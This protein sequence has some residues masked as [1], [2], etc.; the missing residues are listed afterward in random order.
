MSV[1]NVWA[2]EGR[3]TPATMLEEEGTGQRL[4]ASRVPG[5][6]THPVAHGTPDPYAHP[7]YQSALTPSGAGSTCA[8]DLQ[9]AWALGALSVAGG[10]GILC[11]PLGAAGGAVAGAFGIV[12]ANKA[13]LGGLSAARGARTVSIVGVVLCGLQILSIPFWFRGL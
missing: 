6:H 7:S 2:A 12:L 9:V 11:T 13:L 1:L 5:L 4:L 10:V 8:R 3:V